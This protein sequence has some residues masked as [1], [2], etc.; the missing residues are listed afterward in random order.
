[1]YPLVFATLGAALVAF[2]L[3]FAQPQD[4]ER[5]NQARADAY[6]AN[7]WI[8]REALVAFQNDNFKTANGYIQDAALTAPMP[9][10]P[11]GYFPLG[12]SVMQTGTPAV[13]LWKNYFEGGT[14]YTYTTVPA[15]SLPS[16]VIDAISNRNGRSLMIGIKQANGTVTSMF[17]LNTP[18]NT[19]ATFTLPPTSGIPV[20][21]LV[22]IGN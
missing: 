9:Q 13:D 6:A 3:A 22:V 1:M 20:G 21:A 4:I 2:W 8:Y 7:F 10:R 14:L 11:T 5:I 15:S 12:Y 17:R 19:G 18:P 16:G